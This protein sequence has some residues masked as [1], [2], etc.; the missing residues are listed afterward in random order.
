[1]HWL[2]HVMM[3]VLNGLTF[4]EARKR[5]TKAFRDSVQSSASLSDDSFSFSAW[6]LDGYSF[7]S[8]IP[9]V[10][11]ILAYGLALILLKFEYAD[12]LVVVCIL[13]IITLLNFISIT[14]YKQAEK[15]EFARSLFDILSAYESSMNTTNTASIKADSPQLTDPLLASGPT[16]SQDD[17]KTK[18]YLSSGHSQVSIVHTYRD[19]QWMRLPVL[20]LAE[21]DIIALMGGDV[22]PGKCY[23]IERVTGVAGTSS[24]HQTAPADEQPLDDQDN[25][26]SKNPTSWVIGRM[27]NAGEKVHIR[28]RQQVCGPYVILAHRCIRISFSSFCPSYSFRSRNQRNTSNINIIPPI[29]A[30]NT[31]LRR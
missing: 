14:M 19:G 1:M 7:G 21:G 26:F 31:M 4:K 28:N 11:V 2:P 6:K 27:V 9:T 5:V 23:E 10:V 13:T 24:S 3:D 18:A 22:T 29:R 17:F 30:M 16:L 12:L 8:S 20:L 15:R 25:T